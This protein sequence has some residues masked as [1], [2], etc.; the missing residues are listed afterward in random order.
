MST[1]VF[2]PWLRL[3][4]ELGLGG[5]KLLPYQRRKLPAGSKSDLQEAIAAVLEPYVE[6]GTVPGEF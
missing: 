3:D 6:R 4:T 1:L 5:F 2:F